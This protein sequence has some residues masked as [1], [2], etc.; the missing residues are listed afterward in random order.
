MVCSLLEANETGL[1]ECGLR[2]HSISPSNLLLLPCLI[3]EQW[4]T[5]LQYFH[6][7]RVLHNCKVFPIAKADGNQR[8]ASENLDF[9]AAKL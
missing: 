6:I 8:Q 3:R 7:V 5:S 4:L 9:G 1:I 2:Q